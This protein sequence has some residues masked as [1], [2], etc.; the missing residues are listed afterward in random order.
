MIPCEISSVQDWGVGGVVWHEQ[1]KWQQY[2][3]TA[4]V[5]G[6]A[7]LCWHQMMMLG[8]R[9]YL[10]EQLVKIIHLPFSPHLSGVQGPA[11]IQQTASGHS[12][13]LLH[14][15]FIAAQTLSKCIKTWSDSDYSLSLTLNS[16]DTASKNEGSE[17]TFISSFCFNSLL[18]LQLA[19]TIST[20]REKSGVTYWSRFSVFSSANIVA[21]L[22]MPCVHSANCISG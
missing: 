21:Y 14:L 12:Q 20:L 13:E 2:H 1:W 9:L 6:C 8:I 16:W 10:C 15:T 17:E 11:H 22:K 5:G 3:T 19:F 18:P 4:S 7:S